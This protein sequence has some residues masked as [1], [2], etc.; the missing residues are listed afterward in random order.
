MNNINDR[1]EERGARILINN[2]K[3]LVLEISVSS[4]RGRL[5]RMPSFFA[6]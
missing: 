6:K 1:L 4:K 2:R 3:K 5:K